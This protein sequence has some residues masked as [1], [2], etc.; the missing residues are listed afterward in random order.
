MPPGHSCLA[1][2][3]S[4]KGL[5][6]NFLV[7]KKKMVYGNLFLKQCKKDHPKSHSVD[8]RLP[9]LRQ[10]YI[11]PLISTW[12]LWMIFIK[13]LF[14]EWGQIPVDTGRLWEQN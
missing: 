9:Y 13:M 5:K 14:I 2:Y 10:L 4:I 6:I 12:K 8:L 1:F 3:Y 11:L 7:L